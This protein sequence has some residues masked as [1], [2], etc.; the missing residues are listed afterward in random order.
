VI[1]VIIG[2]RYQ[3]KTTLARYFA[4]A[5]R[6]RLIVDPRAQW[7][8]PAADPDDD[9]PV[10]IMDRVDQELVYDELSAGRDVLVQPTDLEYSVAQLAQPS[11]DFITARQDRR[12]TIVLDESS[13]Y[14]EQLR[15]SWSW[16]MR[17]SPVERTT[18]ILTTHRPQDV[19]TDVRALVDTWCFFRTAQE[20]DLEIIEER[21]SA[22]VAQ[23]VQVLKQ[24]EFISWKESNEQGQSEMR[25]HKDP[26]AWFTPAAAPLEGEPLEP[27]RRGLF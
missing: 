27:K 23:R 21:T 20:H 17:C 10:G 1:Y 4:E 24:Y 9:N 5:N 12:L 13:L 22:D 14:K 15:T 11:R 8:T 2:R 16:M 7:P 26:A 18:I 25:H 3:G 6:P 19:P